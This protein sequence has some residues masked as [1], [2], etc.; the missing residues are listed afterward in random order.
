MPWAFDLKQRFK[1]R[2]NDIILFF[3][4]GLW[5]SELWRGGTCVDVARLRCG[6]GQVHVQAREKNV[7]IHG[8]GRFFSV[9]YYYKNDTSMHAHGWYDGPLLPKRLKPWTCVTMHSHAYI[10]YVKALSNTVSMQ[11][12]QKS[13]DMDVQQKNAK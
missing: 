9:D 1:T 12:F 2:K 8:F 4:G 13:C 5:L 10:K 3:L 7:L 11:E 6:D